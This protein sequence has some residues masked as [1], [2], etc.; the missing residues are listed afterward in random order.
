MRKLESEKN[1]AKWSTL[2]CLDRNHKSLE[3]QFK[4][5]ENE[6]V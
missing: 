5:Q 4:G 6:Q 3:C 1:L 2:V